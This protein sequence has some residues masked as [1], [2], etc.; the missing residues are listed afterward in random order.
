MKP[1]HPETLMFLLPFLLNVFGNFLITI[2][3]VL[4][5]YEMDVRVG[6]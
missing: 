1:Y 3:S 5:L 4:S 2:F 6:P